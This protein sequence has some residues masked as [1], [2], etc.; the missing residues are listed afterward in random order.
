MIVF[1]LL[2]LAIFLPVAVVQC[3]P[4]ESPWVT[5]PKGV[6]PRC[7][8]RDIYSLSLAVVNIVTDVLTLLIPFLIFL[9]L[10]V[11]RRVRSALLA[12][13]LL[14][15]L[16][17]IVSGVRLYYIVRLYYHS[18]GDRHFS[19]GYVTSSVE[20]NLAIIT[21]SVPAL[22]PLARRWF[23]GAFETLGINRPYM[24][25][26]IELAYATQR[27]RASRI[28]RGKVIWSKSRHVP[29]GAFAAGMEPRGLGNGGGEGGRAAVKDILAQPGHLVMQGRERTW[30]RSNSSGY[31]GSSRSGEKS[32]QWQGD[33][34]EDDEMSGMTY[35]DAVRGT[36]SRTGGLGGDRGGRNE[37]LQ[38]RVNAAG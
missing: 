13:F 17:T 11:N 18:P 31:S 10:K 24:Y 28:L 1:N 15:G 26:D 6:P 3:L 34:E 4:I 25:P 23:P 27:S 7:I 30:S 5:A 36:E 16:V 33:E 20:I 2:Q 22:W 14:G 9:D 8:R 38:D 29:S 12:V 21:A 32:T 35:H 37:L 19:I